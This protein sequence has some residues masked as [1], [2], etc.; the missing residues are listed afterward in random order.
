MK[1]RFR[2]EGLDGFDPVHALELLLFYAIPR[3]DTKPVARALLD[4][5]G[6]FPA[7]LEA[8]EEEL[9]KVPGMGVNAATFLR[10]L[11]ATGRYYQTRLQDTPV[12]LNTI[13]ECA[14]YLTRHFYGR[15]V[16]TVFFL[17]L[18]AKKRLISCQKL[19]EGDMDASLI[20]TRRLVD[21]LLS[22]NASAVIL[23]HNH[24]SGLA[25]PSLE[26]RLVTQ[27]LSTL[28]D[29]LGIALV[30]H[31]VFS[32]DDWVSMVQSGFLAPRR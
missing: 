2:A 20:P 30:D 4:R 28:L 14:E 18:D 5:F 12:I 22:L 26:D 15:R 17:A 27:K 7:V 10:L 8:P 1:D 24:P 9:T 13:Y 3:V 11:N 25:V 23:A 16:E 6:S 21:T 31:L 32:E 19:A 29:S